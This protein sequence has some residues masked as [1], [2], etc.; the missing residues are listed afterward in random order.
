M[1]D[2]ESPHTGTVVGVEGMRRLGESI[3]QRLQPGDIVLLHG[4][5]GAGKTT[6]AQGIAAGLGVDAAVQSPT[7]TLVADYPARL[8]DGAMATLY[9]L[10]LYR[11]SD[12]EELGEIGWDE[13][14][15]SDDSVML[16]EWPERAG[17]WLPDR[18]LLVSIAYAGHD[19]REV[20]VREVQ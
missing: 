7:F 1:I 14:I 6:L 9:H 3:A 10:D 5:L 2:M 15:A 18:Y 12:S 13:L 11:L 17:D 16:A 19:A 8:A 4:D 20:S